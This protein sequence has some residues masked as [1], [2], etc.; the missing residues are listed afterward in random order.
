MELS[1]KHKKLNKT[2][3]AFVFLTPA[4][5]MFLAFRYYP[6]LQSL[7]FSFFNYTYRNPFNSFVGFDNYIAVLSNPAFLQQMSNTL[8]LFVYGMILGFW[9]PIAQALL[10][11][12]LS[13]KLQGVYRFLFLIP[14][15]IPSVAGM[16]IW[17][18]IWDPSGGLANVITGSL[19]L[20]TYEWLY[21]KELVKFCLRFPYLIGG[22]MNI[23]LYYV[24]IRNIDECLY[25]SARLDGATRFQ[26]MRRITLPLI[27]PIISIQFLL[28]ITHS[29]LAF[30]DIYVMTSGG[31]ANS[32]ATIVYGI[33][34]YVYTY[35]AYGIGMAASVIVLII[36]LTLTSLRLKLQRED[37]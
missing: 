12:E 6:A 27:A 10:L 29:L 1:L 8:I 37:N 26:M 22:S 17:K 21:S 24:A 2:I 20:G 19:G 36:T 5:I 14:S 13:K 31:P 33:Y 4:V 34:N 35:S 23:F 28:S 11:S 9:V 18:Y 7:V 15:A 16:A 30:D 32:S 25:E 3:W